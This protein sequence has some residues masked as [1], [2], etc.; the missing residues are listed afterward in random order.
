MFE[1][2]RLKVRRLVIALAP[3]FLALG[4]GFL[5]LSLSSGFVQA[6]P[7]AQGEVLELVLPVVNAGNQNGRIVWRVKDTGQ[8]YE[9]WQ[10]EKLA[11]VANQQEGAGEQ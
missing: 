11:S 4:L 5:S 6:A 9:K 2:P 7:S 8:T 10:E 3:A 1:K